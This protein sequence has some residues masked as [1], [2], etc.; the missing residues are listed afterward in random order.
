V[1]A[2][3]GR[4][5]VVAALALALSPAGCGSKGGAGDAGTHPP[6]FSACAMTDAGVYSAGIVETSSA[7]LFTTTLVSVS[8]KPTVG[9]PVPVPTIGDATF[10]ITFLD[11]SGLPPVGLKVTAEKPYMPIH[12]HGAP[13]YPTVTDDGGGAFTISKIN[14][15]MAGYWEVTLDLKFPPM[16]VDAGGGD[17]AADAAE[18]MDAD[19]ATDGGA[20]DAASGTDDAASGTDDAAIGTDDAAPGTDGAADD[21]SGV[22]HA[23]PPTTDKIV[24]PICIPS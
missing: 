24:I 8:T 13:T 20:T 3:P 16:V 21:G 6:D 12:R 15:F 18:A 2:I 9:D 4:V 5:A 1:T 11:A 14:F 22:V 10:E 17:G 23:A 19:G 7:R